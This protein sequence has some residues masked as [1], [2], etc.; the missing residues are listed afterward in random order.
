M[1]DKRINVIHAFYFMLGG[2]IS[3]MMLFETAVFRP[4]LF[5]FIYLFS[6][7]IIEKDFFIKILTFPVLLSDGYI[8]GFERKYHV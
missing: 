6:Y 3:N 7:G 5:Y 1:E 8:I 4:F 2:I